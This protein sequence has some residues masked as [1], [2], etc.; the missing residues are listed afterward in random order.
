MSSNILYL[1]IT[2]STFWSG[3]AAAELSKKSAYELLK[4]NSFKWRQTVQLPLEA[5]ALKAQ[6]NAATAGTPHVSLISR[7]YVARINQIEFGFPDP[8]P[9]HLLTF[10]TTAFQLTMSILDASAK[11]RLEAAI[12]N[13]RQSLENQKHYQTEITYVMLLMYLNV[14]RFKK[15]MENIQVSLN[16]DQEIMEIA[17]VRVRMGHGLQ[18]DILR[19]K[20]LIEKDN[21]RRL[22]LSSSYRKA[23][24]EL[25]TLLGLAKVEDDLEPLEIH[26]LLTPPSSEELMKSISHRSDVKSAVLM[27]EVTR[28][29]FLQAEKETSPKL[30]LAGEIGIVG[31]HALGGSGTAVTGSA[32]IQLSVPLFDGGY[33]SGK[34]QE[35][36]AK[37]MEAQYQAG[38][39]ELEAK[40]QVRLA[41]DQL[42]DAR[43]ALDGA[44]IYNE[45][46][47]EEL[48]LVKQRYFA[49]AVS[50]IELSTAQVNLTTA[51][52]A[53]ADAKFG[54]EA[55]KFGYFRATETFEDYFRK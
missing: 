7:E 20:G 31:S 10:G 36:S 46:A 53:D 34:T 35:A 47:G 39:V 52:D 5:G 21:L 3:T 37:N 2:M 27:T 44:K 13:E 49:G 30:G 23:R 18:V 24:Q 48:R 33:F 29:L 22:E 8:G 32:G 15:K 6:A 11:A 4:K 9:L 16:R 51:A 25:S 55:A 54:Y 12:N 17:N 19:A 38:E 50:G 42:N 28:N 41:C 26:S 14:Q 40:S 45:L 1:I 43:T